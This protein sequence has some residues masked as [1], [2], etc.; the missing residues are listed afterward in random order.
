MQR[1]I[2]SLLDPENASEEITFYNGS[3]EGMKKCHQIETT[4]KYQDSDHKARLRYTVIIYFNCGLYPML[5]EWL[6]KKKIC[7]H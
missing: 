6:Q 7:T 4:I 3:V 1:H 5:S 2:I